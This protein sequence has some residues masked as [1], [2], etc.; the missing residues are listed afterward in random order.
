MFALE[1]VSLP[2][3]RERGVAAMPHLESGVVWG[4]V[5]LVAGALV[6][7][8]ALWPTPARRRSLGAVSGA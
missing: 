1:A 2:G 4:T 3:K 8:N 6:I 5:L 7:L